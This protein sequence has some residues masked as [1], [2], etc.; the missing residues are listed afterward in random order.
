MTIDNRTEEM[1]KLLDDKNLVSSITGWLVEQM[2]RT[3]LPT[4]VFW[5]FVLC[6]AMRVI[7]Q[8]LDEEMYRETIEHCMEEQNDYVLNDNIEE[9]NTH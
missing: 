4:P 8:N 7:R 9:G 5:Y 1:K 3:K 6:S 2:N